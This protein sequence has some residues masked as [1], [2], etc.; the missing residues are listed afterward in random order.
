MNRMPEPAPMQYKHDLRVEDRVRYETGEGPE[1]GRVTEVCDEE[2]AF[3][4]FDAGEH[5]CVRTKWLSLETAR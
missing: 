5:R 2:F 1:F 3:V 4:Y